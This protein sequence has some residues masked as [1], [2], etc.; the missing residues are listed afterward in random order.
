[1]SV[2]VIKVYGEVELQEE[3]QK[4]KEQGITPE[5]K[6]SGKSEHGGSFYTLIYDLPMLNEG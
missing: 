1:M 3:L 6:F 5:V 4:L 2:E